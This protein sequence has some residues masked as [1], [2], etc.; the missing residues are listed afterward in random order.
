MIKWH[1]KL[2]PAFFICIAVLFPWMIWLFATLLYIWHFNFFIIELITGSS[3]P[4]QKNFGWAFPKLKILITS[5]LICRKRSDERKT[6]LFFFFFFLFL[7]HCLCMCH[8]P[9]NPVS[10]W[11][12][13]SGWIWTHA[14][15]PAA[16]NTPQCAKLT[17]EMTYITYNYFSHLFT[18]YA[19]IILK[20][21]ILH[22]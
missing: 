6:Q 5:L 2:I 9:K 21:G 13:S 8:C 3:F 10:H 15:G 17:A 19:A 14:H 20:Y 12:L 22:L 16:I 18:K 7:T 11:V 4:F 1:L